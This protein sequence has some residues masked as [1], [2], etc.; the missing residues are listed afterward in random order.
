MSAERISLKIWAAEIEDEINGG[1]DIMI[2]VEAT[3]LVDTFIARKHITAAVKFQLECMPT[4]QFEAEE[5]DDC[6]MWLEN[7]FVYSVAVFGVGEL[8]IPH[9]KLVEVVIDRLLLAPWQRELFG[10]RCT[11]ELELFK[12]YCE[13]VPP[14]PLGIKI[15]Q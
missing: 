7:G 4:T 9:K 13:P 14:G 8:I 2:R 11:V 1:S 6:E 3:A 12:G 15:L 5:E 10:T